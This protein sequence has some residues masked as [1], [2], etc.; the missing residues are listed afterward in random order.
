MV[1]VCIYKCR[2]ICHCSNGK[3]EDGLEFTSID[4]TTKT[5]VETCYA[6]RNKHPVHNTSIYSITVALKLEC[7]PK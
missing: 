2:G 7:A 6:K 1:M 4:S 3:M 5:G